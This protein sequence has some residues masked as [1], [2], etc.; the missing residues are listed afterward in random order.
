MCKVI[1]NFCATD[2]SAAQYAQLFSMLW[3]KSSSKGSRVGHLCHGN[4]MSVLDL[5]FG[6]CHAV[7][8]S[9]HTYVVC[10]A[11]CMVYVPTLAWCLIR[12]H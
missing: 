10:V 8:Y 5:N 3:L 1:I 9:V 4:Q 11:V 7:M 2:M 12:V 6:Y